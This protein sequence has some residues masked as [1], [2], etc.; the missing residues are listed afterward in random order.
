MAAH[1]LH[2]ASSALERL[3]APPRASPRLQRICLIAIALVVVHFVA[4][5]GTA[6]VRRAPDFEYFYK[7]GASL[8]RTGVLDPGLDRLPDGTIEP[9][10][11]IDWYLPFVH[12]LMTPLGLLPIKLA[13][14]LWLLANV[15]IF[16]GTLWLMGR[17]VS[18]LP[19]GDWLV[20]AAVPVLATILFW[21]WEFRLNQVD[22]LTLLLMAAAFVLWRRGRHGLAGFWLGLAVLLKITPA[23]LLVWFGLK[24]QPRIVAAAVVTV[25]LAGPASDAVVFGPRG[26]QEVYAGWFERAFT[27]S[28]SRGLIANQIEMDWRNQGVAAVLCR[29]LHPTSYALRFDNDPRIKIDREPAFVNI[30]EL[31]LPTIARAVDVLMVA[32]LAALAWFC[33]R[34]A[35]RLTPWQLRLEWS[36]VLLA[37]LW[38][39]PVL[40]RYHFIWMTPALTLLVST[41]YYRWSSRTWRF[42]ALGSIGLLV[43][44]QAALLSRLA[45]TDVVEGAG[46]FQF[47][48]LTTIAAVVWMLRRLARN[49]AELAP[50]AFERPRNP[51]AA[52]APSHR[53]TPGNLL[54]EHA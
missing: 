19:P 26:A 34:P 24:R 29:W 40:R 31:S 14:W 54:A 42:A 47:T 10:G 22:N 23:L 53:Q 15:A 38:F 46:V 45:D 5:G 51:A 20:T 11:T 50:D 39:M 30:A 3:P 6:V 4:V 32:G 17:Y 37:T 13:G 33:R 18:G 36:L 43:L 28:S 21:H 9:R 35:A 1:A 16:F 48:L 25:L 7:A 2:D 8:A 12:R 44:G 52:P 27:R 49:P 41:A